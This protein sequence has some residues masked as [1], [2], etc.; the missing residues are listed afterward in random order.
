MSSKHSVKEFSFIS[1]F[2]FSHN[3]CDCC[4][5]PDDNLDE[6]EVAFKVED[7]GE[8]KEEDKENL[9]VLDEDV[10]GMNDD[11][12]KDRY[13][14]TKEEM[15]EKLSFNKGIVDSDDLLPLNVNRETL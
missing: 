13:K 9:E 7:R 10:D 6:D 2:L 14:N 12:E 11:E 3:S 8:K 1:Y 4:T 15:P 5:I